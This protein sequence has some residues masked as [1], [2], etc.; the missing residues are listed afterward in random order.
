M[1]DKI[2]KLLREALGVPEGI[3]DAANN[4][5]D[6]ILHEFIDEDSESKEDEYEFDIDEKFTIGKNN[7]YTINGFIFK[8]VVEEY[9]HIDKLFIL[10]FGF[11]NRHQIEVNKGIRLVNVPSHKI[12]LMCK[13]AV[14]ESGW[15]FNDILELFETRKEDIISSLAH[16]LKHA[17]DAHKKQKISPYNTA[18]Y[19]AYSNTRTGL[20]PIDK[21]VNNLYFIHSIESL[22][23]PSEIGSI[24]KQRGVK[25]K[26]FLDFLT[27]NDIYKKLKAISNFSV[28]DLREELKEYISQINK[29]LEILELP[30]DISDEDKVEKMLDITYKTLIN[31][32]GQSI[33]NITTNPMEKMISIIDSD[34]KEF[35]DKMINTINRFPTYKEFFDYEEK[36]FRF[37]SKKIIKKISKLYAMTDVNETSIKEWDLYQQTNKNRFEGFVKESKYIKKK[38]NKK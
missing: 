28:D 26:E 31:V 36:M 34:K 24:M 12:H 37:T 38:P 10:A 1:R 33:F 35:I 8:V 20:P 21:F 14:P 22:V 18:M 27:N 7:D 30:T 13:I 25:Q 5:Y 15:E 4:L 16:E 3:L 2:K 17:Y 32:K 29:I 9:D 6:I 23:R 11:G 19:H